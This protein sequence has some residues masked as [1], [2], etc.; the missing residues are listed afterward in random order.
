[1]WNTLF[2]V[3]HGKSVV[4][5]T[6]H[7]HTTRCMKYGCGHICTRRWSGGGFFDGLYHTARHI[8]GEIISIKMLQKTTVSQT[9]SRDLAQWIKLATVTPSQ[10]PPVTQ[11][12]HTPNY[13]YVIKKNASNKEGGLDTE[14]KTL[15]KLISSGRIFGIDQLTWFEKW[16]L[17]G[18]GVSSI[19]SSVSR[20]D[21]VT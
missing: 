13:E 17:Y 19:Y 5:D 6:S 16:S 1:M 18:S 9:C 15:N 10:H 4:V 3:L 2:S 14:S 20:T 8:I 11:M 12:R 21:S 7:V